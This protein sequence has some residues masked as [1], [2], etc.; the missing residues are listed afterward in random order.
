MPVA[1]KQNWFGCLW[2]YVLHV[3]VPKSKLAAA[4][5]VED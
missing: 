3:L 1:R 5:A 2:D 4:V